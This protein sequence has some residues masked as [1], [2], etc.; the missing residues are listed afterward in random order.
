MGADVC[1]IAGIWQRS[2]ERVDLLALE[3][4]GQM[5]AHRGPD[6]A[7][8]HLDGEIGLANRRL[9][10]IDATPAGDQPM[11]LSDGSLWL[12]FN[13]EIHNYRELRQEL[14]ARGVRF[15]TRTDTE[16]VL[17]AYAIWGTECFERFNG[18]WAAALWSAR[19]QQLVLSRD[20]FGIKPLYYALRGDRICFASEPKAILAA[21]PEE[22]R[23]D[24][25]EIERFLAGGTP[26]IGERTFFASIKSLSPA[27]YSVFSRDAMRSSTYW[28]FT[29]GDEDPVPDTEERFRALLADAV[30]LRTKSDVPIGACVSGG[31]DSSAIVGLLDRSGPGPMHCFSLQYDESSFDE[32]RYAALAARGPGLV[33]HWVRPD[34]HGMLDTM[35]KIVW[36]H[37]AP[38]R[39]RG[40]FGQWFVM[41]EAGR[42]VKVVL[43]GQGGDELLGGYSHHV[44]P[45]LIDR[46]RRIAP[47]A[48]ASR[49][50]LREVADLG[51][52][53][54]P[55]PF[56]LLTAPLRYA[57]D[58]RLHGPRPYSS[59]LNN[60]L[61]NEL[62]YDG[63]REILHAEDA[64]SMAFSVESRTPFLD[65]RLV[66]LCFRLPFY[67]KISD[68]RTKSL[69]R[70]A[71]SEDVPQAV[72]AR[73][74]KLGFPAPVAPWLRLEDN[75]RA[76]RDLLLDPR[77]LQ[78]G[79]RS[80]RKVEATL[81][82][83]Y[84]GRSLHPSTAAARLWTWITLEL[85]FRDFVDRTGFD[86]SPVVGADSRAARTGP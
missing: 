7:G 57:R 71:L 34:R 22:G 27:T 31:L 47:E 40:R 11:G 64:M 25:P 45:Y 56:F 8:V 17:N 44:V 38:T 21:F 1:G 12:T 73:R 41:S 85:W 55:R 14:E 61:W 39:M 35:R 50:L 2:G 58:P 66:E 52:V 37:D 43:D 19:D 83:F 72:L 13:G 4:M 10:I 53:E 24:E 33:T 82:A 69:L 6:G 59:M 81:K 23:P 68:G 51:K 36:H 9:R 42:H 15:R 62:R 80:P 32:S 54:T 84:G 3:S 16:V 5:L 65:H 67:E 46:A 20:R 26:D 30:R 60:M 86:G 78:R 49:C 70:R 63:L 18:M 76:V 48:P 77:S 28:Q 74:R 29:P 79:V 75:R